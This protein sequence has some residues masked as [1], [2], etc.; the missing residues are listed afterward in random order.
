[1]II[2]ASDP[3]ALPEG[4]MRP[5]PVACT[6]KQYAAG[7]S[8]VHRKSNTSLYVAMYV[9]ERSQSERFGDVFCWKTVRFRGSVAAL[10]SNTPPD[11]DLHTREGI[12]LRAAFFGRA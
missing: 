3:A 1:M 11:F 9:L 12:S 5:I 10:E 6:G 7:L 8:R 2:N 4:N